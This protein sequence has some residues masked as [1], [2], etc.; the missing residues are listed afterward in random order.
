M[1][2]DQK[3]PHPH[4]H[5]KPGRHPHDDTTSGASLPSS[6]LVDWRHI[7]FLM[8]DSSETT[9]R[10]DAVAARGSVRDKHWSADLRMIHPLPL[11]GV[12]SLKEQEFQVCLGIHDRVGHETHRAPS[13]ALV[14]AH[15]LTRV[16]DR[17]ADALLNGR[18]RSVTGIG[19]DKR[20]NPSH[21]KQIK[22]HLEAVR[23]TALEISKFKDRP[24][25]PQTTMALLSTQT[26]HAALE[27]TTRLSS[28]PT[29]VI[30]RFQGDVPVSDQEW[31]PTDLRDATKHR[32]PTLVRQGDPRSP[33]DGL[34]LKERAN[35]GAINITQIACALLGISPIPDHLL[36]QGLQADTKVDRAG[37]PMPS[38]LTT[39]IW[40]RRNAIR[41]VLTSLTREIHGRP[42]K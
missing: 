9:H 20:H 16:T 17:Q 28:C 34:R 22:A 41:E 29:L 10:E 18:E 1:T 24:L 42:P 15:N 31:K 13:V 25:T 12:V 26:Q 35:S 21:L 32:V 14:M 33:L 5:S 40:D 7:P 23:A 8:L 11:R 37:R 27:A 6:K 36:K 3:H 38:A 39:A 2:R 19:G 30:L 4:Q